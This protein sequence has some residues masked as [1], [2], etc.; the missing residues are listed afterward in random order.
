MS[1]GNKKEKKQNNLSGTVIHLGLLVDFGQELENQSVV[2][3]RVNTS[4]QR[5]QRSEKSGG[6][7]AQRSDRHQVFDPVQIQSG[8]RVRK[9]CVWLDQPVRDQER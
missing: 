5:V 8:E 4:G 9:S 1:E 6:H 2:G 7:S 3:H